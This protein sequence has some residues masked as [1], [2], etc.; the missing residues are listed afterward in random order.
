MTTPSTSS[1]TPLHDR[2]PR[3][4]ASSNARARVRRRCARALDTRAASRDDVAR[5]DARERARDTRAAS[6]D[7]DA[8]DDARARF[9]PP[10]P[11][12]DPHPPL[13]T[14]F[15]ARRC[16]EARERGDATA[17]VSFDFSKT[18][19]VNAALS[20]TG[21]RATMGGR[22]V[23]VA[24]DDVETMAADARGVY[25]PVNEDDWTTGGFRKVV[26]YSEDTN[27]AVSLMPTGDGTWPTALIA[28]FSMHR[29]GVGVDP[30]EDTEK[31]LVSA[32]PIR[33]GARVLDVCTGLAYTSCV[34]SEKYGARVTTIELD[35]T[36]TAMCRVNP[37]S[38]P[39][40]EGGIEQ[41]YGNG[42]D[43][44]KTL[45]D[46]EFDVIVHDPPTFSL[47]GELYSTEFYA[48][49]KRVLKS[50]GRIYHYIGDPK[51]ASGSGVAAGVVRRLKEIGFDA[52]IDYDAH[53]VVA[54][55]GRVR[56]NRAKKQ[57]SRSPP[58]GGRA[59]SRARRPGRGAGRGAGRRRR[60]SD[61][62]DDDDDDDDEYYY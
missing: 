59:S 38:R 25:E 19:R 9:E 14:A 31:K 47:A 56:L 45:P 6:R 52:A 13:V 61:D 12:L 15:E 8:R 35:R 26:R 16:V 17:S 53:G 49:L 36:M 30:K 4:R 46:A 50:K 1:S 2:V 32:G 58:D 43:V 20:S 28:G 5:D 55:R 51:S 44:V 18:P 21:V 27:R 29:F 22:D 57:A 33:K 62:D 34:A 23:F 24:W 3:A 10:L 11:A 54:S 60:R 39:L 40:F 37:H 41:L 7:D 48:E 42:A